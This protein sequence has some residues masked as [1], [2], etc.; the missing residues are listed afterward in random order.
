[1]SKLSL[2][3]NIEQKVLAY[4]KYPSTLNKRAMYS[5]YRKAKKAI[6][7]SYQKPKTP[8]VTDV[9]PNWIKGF[10]YEQQ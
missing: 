5:A 2:I 3:E 1:M 6:K 4:E 9:V 8:I 7:N 10:L